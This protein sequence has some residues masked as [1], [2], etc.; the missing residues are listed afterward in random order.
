MKA[1]GEASDE[2]LVRLSRDGDQSAFATLVDRHRPALRAVCARLLRDPHDREELQQEVMVRAWIRI[3]TYD[4]RAPL[5]GW[6]RRIAA[7]AAIDE[8]RRRG[9]API[10]VDP[11][12]TLWPAHESPE[13]TVVDEAHLSWALGRL[14]AK[15][16]EISVL[17]DRLGYPPAEIARFY[18]LPEATVRTRLRR[19]RQALRELLR[20]ERETFI[21]ERSPERPAARHV[22]AIPSASGAGL[23]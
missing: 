3:G 23:R 13:Q 11:A 15:Y 18:D 16:R 4:E 8:Y 20:P 5:A 2:S 14:P 17:A 6:L 7:N 10:P 21:R 9:R 1:Y 12:V 22:P 19:A